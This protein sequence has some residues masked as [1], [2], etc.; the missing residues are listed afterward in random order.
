MLAT[1]HDIK[2]INKKLFIASMMTLIQMNF[3]RPEV[4]AGEARNLGWLL[5]KRD[6]VE[7]LIDFEEQH[8]NIIEE[9][10]KELNDG[11]NMPNSGYDAEN[12]TLMAAKV[13]DMENRTGWNN[14]DA[15][16]DDRV[17]I[18]TSV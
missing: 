4:Y 2:S 13:K 9:R 12:T 10:V 3:N 15:V 5:G 16:K 6:R 7:E 17:Y 11:E 14:I 1:Y 18:I 8:L